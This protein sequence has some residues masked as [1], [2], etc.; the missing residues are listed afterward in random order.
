M[1]QRRSVDQETCGSIRQETNHRTN[2][3]T[4]AKKRHIEVSERKPKINWP[5]ASEAGKYRQFDDTMSEVISNLRENPEWSNMESSYHPL[6]MTSRQANFVHKVI[7]IVAV[8]TQNI[9]KQ[10][11]NLK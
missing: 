6:C 11:N 7:I 1:L 5:K 9:K 3:T 10:L 2:H 8:T 4:A